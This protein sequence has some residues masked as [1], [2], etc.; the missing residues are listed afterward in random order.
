[1]KNS[2]KKLILF[3]FPWM[4]CANSITITPDTLTASIQYGEITTE[5][6]T[7]TNSNNFPVN[8]DISILEQSK[9]DLGW[10]FNL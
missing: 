1:M 8:L 5:T 10:N 3:S 6:I 2:Y 9:L 4:L 7:I